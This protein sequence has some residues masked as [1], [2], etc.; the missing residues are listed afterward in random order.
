MQ[1]ARSKKTKFINIIKALDEALKMPELEFKE[2]IN[3]I[4]DSYFSMHDNRD[5]D[6][7]INQLFLSFYRDP[8][9]KK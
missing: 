9:F 6:P 2:A 8:S 4:V 7:A 1:P 5:I 3:T